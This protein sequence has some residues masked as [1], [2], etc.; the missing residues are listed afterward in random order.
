MIAH[1]SF[2]F[3]LGEPL[4]C[5]PDGEA[6]ALFALG[7]LGPDVYFFDQFPPTPFLPN[8]K[9]HGNRLH[10]VPCDALCRALMQLSDDALRPYVY[11]F[12]THI[13]LDSTLHPYICARYPSGL[14]H[15][16]FEGD[17]DAV[18][19]ERYKDRFD[20]RHIFPMPKQIDRLDALMTDV[21]RK[22]VDA[23]IYGA[24]RRSARKLL[25]LYPL[26]FDPDAK[27]FRFF[28]ALEKPLH[29]TGAISGL[30]VGPPHAYF[31]DCM[32]TQRTPWRAP[33]KPDVERTET[34]DELFAEAKAFAE[35]LIRAA[36][37]NDVETLCA[38]T[39]DRTL[40][41]GPLS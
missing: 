27:R 2:A 24:Y 32:N 12:L 15:T 38:L 4:G 28:A 17:I 20:F 23:G 25:R 3:S 1:T 21:S 31:S 5:C 13:A 7:C 19:Y 9:P 36:Q 29:K 35:Q 34:V 22:V 16:R 11:G 40:E 26:L 14:D 37:A 41:A 6:R 18:L 33:A 8:Q 30:L 10:G 39:A